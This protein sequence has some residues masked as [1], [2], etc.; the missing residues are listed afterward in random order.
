MIILSHLKNTRQ[1]CQW[2]LEQIKSCTYRQFTT[3]FFYGKPSEET[4]DIRLTI[5]DEKGY[6]YSRYRR[7]HQMKKVSYNRNGAEKHSFSVGEQIEIM[8]HKR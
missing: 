7:M 2:Y 5:L 8:K 1:I 3:G 6:T 4:P